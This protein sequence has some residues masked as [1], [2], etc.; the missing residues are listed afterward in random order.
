MPRRASSAG[1]PM[2]DGPSLFEPHWSETSSVEALVESYPG[3]TPRSAI[4]VSTLTQT[5]K[6]V[7]EGAFPPLW[8]RGEVSDF[9]SHRNGHW[10]FSLRDRTAQ[11]RCVVWSRDQM[12]I[13]AAPDDG[14][15]VTVLGQ[16]G[17]YPARGD[18]QFTIKRIDADGEGLWRKAL[19]A[20]RARL[21]ADGLFAV[22]R[23]RALPRHPRRIAMVTSASGAALHD[24]ISVLRRRAPGV[25]LI[26]SH[27]AVQGES[28]PLELRAALDRVI[29]WGGAD[30]VIIGRGGGSRE[31]LWA[32]NDERL[33]RAVANCP[34]PRS[35]RWG[36]RS[37]FHCATWLLIYAPPRRPRRRRQRS[38]HAKR[39]PW[40]LSGCVVVWCWPLTSGCMNLVLAPP[41]PRIPWPR[42]PTHTSD[43]G[44]T[45]WHRCPGGSMH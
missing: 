17:V 4:T 11:L 23:K 25:E 5:A 24:V 28:A 7:L 19:E 3:E 8:V 27:A 21:D 20:T 18:M 2:G 36:T 35:L 10:Y 43:C 31:D 30:L 40:R 34:I 22:H 12:G 9:K 14:M 6:E 33:V 32:F 16:L 38:R 39:S 26:L 13:P 44:N 45:A 29:R 37:I 42:P 15:Q 1:A 41:R